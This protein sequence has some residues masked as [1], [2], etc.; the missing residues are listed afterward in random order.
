MFPTL[1]RFVWAA[2]LTLLL[3]TLGLHLAH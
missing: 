2:L 1:P 3:L